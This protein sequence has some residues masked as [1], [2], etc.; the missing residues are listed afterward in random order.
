MV[1]C[2]PQIAVGLLEPLDARGDEGHNALLISRRNNRQF[3]VGLDNKAGIV[4][5]IVDSSGK[6][7]G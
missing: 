5:R 1:T 3:A 6:R 2:A 4:Q 7:I